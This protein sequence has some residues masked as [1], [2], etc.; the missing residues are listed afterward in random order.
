[1]IMTIQSIDRTLGATGA[2]ATSA[3]SPSSATGPAPTILPEPSP[4]LLGGDI[5]AEI[6]ALAVQAGQTERALD[7]SA[8]QTEDA[9]Q[10]QAEQGE[11][12]TLH[13]EASTMRATAWESGCLQIA[14]G[15]ASIAGGVGGMEGDKGFEGLMKGASEGLGGGAT[16]AG[17]LGKAAETDSEALAAAEKATSDAAEREGDAARSAQK[18][19]TAFITAAIDFYR[20]YQS[21]K[22]QA[23]AAAVHGA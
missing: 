14:G 22:A 9:V 10:D 20:E 3:A 12:S 15:A 11:V 23:N 8:E 13:Q 21:T 17:G 6:T 5:G 4:Y 1:M 18:D 7:T 19:A 2:F 16:L